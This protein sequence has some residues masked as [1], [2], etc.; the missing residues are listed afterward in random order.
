MQPLYDKYLLRLVQVGVLINKTVI[1]LFLVSKFISYK[2]KSGKGFWESSPHL[3]S[4]CRNTLLVT[5]SW[6]QLTNI[7]LN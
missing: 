2:R 4:I 3:V 5:I 6:K 1:L 7:E